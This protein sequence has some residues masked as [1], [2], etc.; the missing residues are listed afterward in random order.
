MNNTE[1]TFQS[2]TSF[3]PERWLADHGDVLW[4]F[5][6]ARVQDPHLAE[7]L[8]QDSL[9]SAWRARDSFRGSSTERTWL[10]GILR[11]KIADWRRRN[12]RPDHR[13]T[14]LTEQRYDHKGLWQIDPGTWPENPAAVMQRP[15]F[16]R[17]FEKCLARLPVTVAEA[18]VLRE[19]RQVATQAACE[20]LGISAENLWVR[21][22]RARQ[23]LRDCLALDWKGL[24][25]GNP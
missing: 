13:H 11:Y 2:S 5:A 16:W 6:L 8:V 4:R 12:G 22:H 3:A 25:G 15:E 24:Q 18:F 10:V 21:V 17:A 9:L 20:T 1:A 7:E 23:S 19:V 14:S